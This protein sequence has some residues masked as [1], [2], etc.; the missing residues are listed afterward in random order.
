VSGARIVAEA[1]RQLRARD[2]ILF[3]FVGEGEEKS[4]VES[5]SR[6]YGLGNMRFLPFQPRERLSEVQ[7]TAD[8]AMVTLAPGRGRTSVPSKVLGYMAAGRPI[9]GSVDADADTA[10]VITD[11]DLGLVVPPGDPALLADAVVQLA[12]DEPARRRHGAKARALLEE[13][14]STARVLA[15]Y[16]RS[17]RQ[18]LDR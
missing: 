2:D 5:K 4:L 17:L 9:L 13:R 16:E 1:A 3:L 15:E 12:D 10:T 6:E 7:A 11:N 8:L 14:Y 18:L